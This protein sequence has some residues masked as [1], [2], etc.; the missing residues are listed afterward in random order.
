VV[1]DVLS[2]D[3]NAASVATGASMTTG[4]YKALYLDLVLSAVAGK[5]GTSTLTILGE[6][7]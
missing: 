7:P 5:T 2:A 1:N 6:T 4:T 3:G